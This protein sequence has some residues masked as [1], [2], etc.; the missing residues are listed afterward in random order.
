MI[1]QCL[2]QGLSA[3]PLTQMRLVEYRSGMICGLGVV[4]LPPHDLTAVDIHDQV[5]IEVQALDRRGQIGDIPTSQL[6]RSAGLQRCR[7]MVPG[8]LSFAAVGQLVGLAQHPVEA[9]FRGDVTTTVSQYR[10]D[11][12]W[13]RILAKL[14]TDSGRT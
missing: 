4:D 5:E 8:C 10:D 1:L 7:A 14:N 11:L 9:R 6:V 12:A 13:V 3:N 2:E